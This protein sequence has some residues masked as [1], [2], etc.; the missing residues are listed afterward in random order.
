MTLLPTYPTVSGLKGYQRDTLDVLRR[1]VE[2]V[3]QYRSQGNDGAS[4]LAFSDLRNQGWQALTE[5]SDTPFVCLKVPT[6]GG[7]TLIAAHG[8]GIVY[9]ELLRDKNQR[10]IVL[11]LTPNDTIREQT[12]RALKDP[13][14]P[15]RRVLDDAFYNVPVHVFRNAEA[16]QM[17]PDQVR[18]GLSIIVSTMQALKAKDTD[19]LKFYQPNGDLLQFATADEKA[20]GVAPS[21]YDVVKRSEPLIVADEGHN[22]KTVLALDVIDSLNPSFVLELTATP[23]DNSN[24][25]VSISAFELKKEQMVKLP[26]NLSIVP[27]WEGAL[28]KAHEK[29]EGLD[30]KA[31]EE[32]VNGTGEYIRPILLIQAE[33]DKRSTRRPEAVDA[34]RVKDY[35]KN[36]L[37]VPEEQVKIKTGS[38]DE[39]GS[40][41]LMAEDVEVRYIITRDA[42]KEGW[43]APFAYVLA[44]MYNLSKVKTIEQLLGRILRL[45]N[46]RKKHHQEL[47]ESYVYTTSPQFK[48]TLDIIVTSMENNGYGREEVRL[49]GTVDHYVDYPITMMAG[50]TGLRIPLLAVEEGGGYPR[51]V[52]WAEDF[53]EPGFSVSKA[54]VDAEPLN[55]QQ[56]G[57][58]RLDLRE[59]KEWDKD[60]LAPLS[61]LTGIEATRD[62]LVEWL[63]HKIGSYK[64][65]TDADLR[66]YIEKVLDE[67]ENQHTFEELYRAKYQIRDRIKNKLDAHYVSWGKR[68]YQEVKNGNGAK[69]LVADPDVAYCIPDKLESYKSQCAVPYPKSVFEYP[70]KLNKEETELVIRLGGL[71]NVDWW[72][73]NPDKGGFS[74]Q[75]YRKSRFNPDFVAFIGDKV[76]V[77]EYKGG[78]RLS[79]ED[80]QYKVKIGNDW[81]ALDPKHR[82]FWLVSK[83]NMEDVLKEVGSL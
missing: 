33:V 82:R 43:D 65:V 9:D 61:D 60:I 26:V 30:A 32:R 55:E 11:W 39:L 8:V 57:R 51:E 50:K 58:V 45:P 12:L 69:R 6:G 73:R 24:V 44:S 5:N 25:L 13:N 54:D 62:D 46:V 23:H 83:D 2:G 74:L 31:R 79:N 68:R 81:A 41:D 3:M 14:H 72:Y 38:T 29:R 36:V 64:E 7:K 56:I 37:N 67:L 4:R 75:G 71:S 27:D 77:L 17:R 49:T 28:R 16:L 70:G 10:G 34:A 59:D 40:T 18:G 80:T 20:E 21:L 1:Y 53:L 76:V 15:Y 52:R 42:L 19:P 63:L 78:D 22:A 47:N 48:N 35:L 66:A